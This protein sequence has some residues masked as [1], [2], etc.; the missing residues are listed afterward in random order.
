[1]LL[2]FNKKEQ[3]QL[4]LLR[5]L[6]EKQDYCSFQ[7]LAECLDVSVNTLKE[8]AVYLENTFDQ[9]LTIQKD[10]FGLRVYY[11]MSSSFLDVYHYYMSESLY[12][13][14]MEYI[15]FN[16]QEKFDNIS[17]DN[18]TSSATISRAFQ[19]MNEQFENVY[20]F[21][22][23]TNPV[24]VVGDEMSIRAF[25][26]NFFR[27]KYGLLGWP[28]PEIDEE[29]L[30]AL[31]KII[32]NVVQ[33]ELKYD[34]FLYFKHVT[35]ISFYRV[36]QGYLISP[37]KFNSKITFLLNYFKFHPGF[38]KHKRKIESGINIK[39][40]DKN[41]IQS[42][43]LF[44]SKDLTLVTMGLENLL[45]N[46]KKV[47]K[48]YKLLDQGISDL[49]TRFNLEIEDDERQHLIHW[50]YNSAH[51]KEMNLGFEP[52]LIDHV[53]AY[54]KYSSAYF[55]VFHQALVE[56]L[57]DFLGLAFGD[58]SDQLISFVV[59]RFYVSW[60]RVITQLLKQT[61]QV[62]VLIISYIYSGRAKVMKNILELG[63]PQDVS[64]TV[65][66]ADEFNMDDI[67]NSDYDLIVADFDL[68]DDTDKPVLSIQNLPDHH[69]MLRFYKMIK[70]VRINNLN[71]K[72]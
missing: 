71:K 10:S 43:A 45:G 24:Q 70:Q 14:L 56:L 54:V 65:Y 40:T 37:D 44:L 20:D 6:S 42:F 39:L 21:Q 3:R 57:E 9:Y 4:R 16:P 18:F 7:S 23:I 38:L 1:M 63:A 68:S 48:I 58:Y 13:Q 26:I 28:Y 61:E 35:A 47:K 52:I 62:S 67:V 34:H 25:Y 29:S 53:S 60:P 12:F 8:D 33:V 36:K 5:Y 49:I 46:Q 17:N 69:D 41:L 11:K 27:E 32:L 59:Y 66:E 72:R 2:M 31:L 55:S 64:F 22:I 15:F 50:L 19:H 30:E 51:L